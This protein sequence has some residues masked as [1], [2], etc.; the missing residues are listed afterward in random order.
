VDIRRTRL[1]RA[2]VALLALALL[3]AGCG[4]DDDEGEETGASTPSTAGRD[5]DEGGTA[6]GLEGLDPGAP[7]KVGVLL[8]LSGP[9]GVI[10]EI[11]L[12]GIEIAVDELNAE[13]GV[14]GHPIELAVRD[15]GGDPTQAVSLAQELVQREGVKFILGTTLSSPALAVFEYLTEAE[16]PMMGSQSADQVAD[17]ER[18]PFGFSMSPLTSVQAATVVALS[19]EAFE[20]GVVGV[21]AEAT[22][23][24]DSFLAGFEAEL[25]TQ[26]FTNVVTERYEQGSADVAPQLR[27]LRDAGVET[28]FAASLGADVARIVRT[29]SQ[30]LGWDVPIVIPSGS[31]AETVEQAGGP[32]AVSSLHAFMSRKH[33]YPEGGEPDPAA[34]AYAELLKEKLG[35]DPL[36]T[37]LGQDSAFYD[38][39]HLM[40]FSFEEAGTVDGPAVRDALETMEWPDGSY[41]EWDMNPE[42]H[43]SITVEDQ[44]LVRA[45]TFR[46]G[47]FQ[48]IGDEAE[49]DAGD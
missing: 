30:E 25:E 38:V 17:P 28:I 40:A 34:A 13:G 47:F 26:Q 10:G 27:N 3:A 33:T 43:T 32:A 23:F 46:D 6:E 12:R 42:T 24:G 2:V 16:V 14:A 22:A 9:Q 45:D 31:L 48:R 41:A 7:L 8:S 19:L 36:E 39:V 11:Q 29:A 20:P 35:Q 21:L 37:G 15:D 44:A 4:D 18:Y 49:T 1:S 5:A